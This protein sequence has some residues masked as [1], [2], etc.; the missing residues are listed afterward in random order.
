MLV[1]TRQLSEFVSKNMSGMDP[2]AVPGFNALSNADRKAV[3][4]EMHWL[5]VRV[6]DLFCILLSQPLDSPRCAIR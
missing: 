1:F 3:E 5:Q 6:V 2:S 4:E